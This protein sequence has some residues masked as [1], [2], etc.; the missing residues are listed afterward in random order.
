MLDPDIPPGW[1]YNPSEWSERLPVLVLALAGCGIA[2]YLALYQVGVIPNVWEPF[3][4]KGSSLILRQSSV[5]HLL[6]IPDAALGAVAY[7][8]EAIADGVGGRSRWRTMPWVVLLLG[9]IAGALGLVGILLAIFQP[10]LFGAFCTLC[11]ASAACSVLAAGAV[12]DEVLASLRHLAREHARGRSWWQALWGP[13][14][15]VPA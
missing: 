10:A 4:G 1:S 13:G 5:A 9:L 11:L 14:S 6:P 2:A 12:V 7:L 3:F 15:G 8:L